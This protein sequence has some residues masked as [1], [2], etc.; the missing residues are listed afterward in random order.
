MLARMS[1]IESLLRVPG[2]FDLS[3]PPA[4]GPDTRPERLDIETI[5]RHLASFRPSDETRD[6]IRSALY[7]WHDHLDESHTISQSIESRDGSLLHAL[8][9]RREPDYGN[10]KYWWRRAGDHPSFGLLLTAARSSPGLAQPPPELARLLAAPRWDPFAFVDLCERAARSDNSK[11][12][13]A[14]RPVQALEFQAFFQ[15]LAPSA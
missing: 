11:L 12:S 13:E 2:L 4:L 14:G 6:L 9:H 1:A 3:R 10:S 5:D 8:M 15:S 7:L